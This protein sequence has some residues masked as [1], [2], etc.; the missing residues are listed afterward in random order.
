MLSRPVVYPSHRIAV[1]L[2]HQACPLPEFHDE[3][4]KFWLRL[5]DA[6]VPPEEDVAVV[7]VRQ[8]TV[9]EEG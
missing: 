6:I 1:R 5:R 4:V 2:F 3:V 7:V 9:P 8:T